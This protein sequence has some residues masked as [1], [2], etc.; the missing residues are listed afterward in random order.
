MPDRSRVRCPSRWSRILLA[1]GG[2]AKLAAA[3]RSTREQRLHRHARDRARRHRPSEPGRRRARRIGGFRLLPTGGLRPRCRL[4]LAARA[5]ALARRPVLPAARAT[6][7]ACASC[8]SSAPPARRGVRV[9]LL[10]DDLYTGGEDE[11]FRSFAALPNVQVR[12]FNPAAGARRLAATR[13][14][15]SLHEFSRIN[16]RMH[17]KLFVADNRF[18][19]SGGRNM[20]DEYFMRSA[21]A[22]F[23]D[24]DVVAAGPVV[25]EQSRCSIAT[26]T[27]STRGRCE[28]VV[29]AG[30]DTATAQQRF[31]ELVEKAAP[32]LPLTPND[33]LGRLAVG[34]ELAADAS[35]SRSRAPRSSPTRPPRSTAPTTPRTSPPSRAAPSRRSPGAP[36]SA[37]RLAVL[38]PRA[39][40]HGHDD[41]RRDRT[42]SASSS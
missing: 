8:A 39:D 33:P 24:M 20:A 29:A 9:R 41:R 7:S 22:N 28:S 4:A 14:V 11:L 1:L 15:F 34:V 23:I 19:I 25:R 31:D 36:G 13:L 6:A 40:R 17:N 18:S 42:A 38:H 3:A 2:C 10:V 27:A 12:L 5:E 21:S 26:G 35:R 16:H 32:D 30:V 37:G